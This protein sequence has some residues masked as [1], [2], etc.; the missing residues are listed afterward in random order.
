M[1][2]YLFLLSVFFIFFSMEE[3]FPSTEIDTND[4]T[5]FVQTVVRNSDS[6]LVTYLESTKMTY[7]DDSS[8]L[9]FLE[10]ESIVGKSGKLTIDGHEFQVIR[11]MQQ[12]DIDSDLLISNTKLIDPQNENKVILLFVHDGYPT[13]PGDTV[14]TFWTFLIPQT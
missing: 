6:Q 5:I 9:L 3:S 10:F 11:R 1:K 13:T 8:L 12:I 2:K 4:I 14:Q 7:V